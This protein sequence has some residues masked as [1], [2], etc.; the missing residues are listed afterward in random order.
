MFTVFVPLSSFLC[1]ILTV[2]A[3]PISERLKDKNWMRTDY[4]L[5]VPDYVFLK[6]RENQKYPRP[7]KGNPP[8]LPCVDPSE[9]NVYE[10]YLEATTK[11]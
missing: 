5:L 7:P 11:M 6:P 2:N 4:G 3:D 8:S 1:Y 9:Y 10:T